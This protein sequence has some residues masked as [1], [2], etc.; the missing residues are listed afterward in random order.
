MAPYPSLYA[1]GQEQQRV[2]DR[3]T[4]SSDVR[5]LDNFLSSQGA[6]RIMEIIAMST[7]P[8][9][10]TVSEEKRESL[11]AVASHSSWVSPSLTGIANPEPLAMESLRSKLNPGRFQRRISE[12]T[13]NDAA[14]LLNMVND[15]EE[16]RPSSASGA[17]AKT[18]GRKPYNVI[19][20]TRA[21]HA[22][23][24]DVKS[25]DQDE[26]A[27]L[28]ETAT[29]AGVSTELLNQMTARPSRIF[30][31]DDSGVVVLESLRRATPPPLRLR[32]RMRRLV[33][34]L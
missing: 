16:R 9:T 7:A 18:K 5:P 27:T 17:E 25:T 4:S 32:S 2:A 3:Y 19:V 8:R 15:I 10:A 1:N 30:G 34:S 29:A 31:D 11:T 14:H 33:S 23:S 26:R 20:S 24:S 22:G 12:Y 6:Q 28:V 13:A 21:P